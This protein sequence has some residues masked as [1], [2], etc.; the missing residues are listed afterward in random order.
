MNS[1]FTVRTRERQDLAIGRITISKSVF[2]RC[3]RYCHSWSM[4]DT[5][6]TTGRCM[7]GVMR[8]EDEQREEEEH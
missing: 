5:Q 3:F 6:N 1:G 8:C 4:L 7:A 2:D